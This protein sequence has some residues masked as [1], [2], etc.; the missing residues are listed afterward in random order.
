MI[1]ID[2]LLSLA[3]MSWESKSQAR[4]D[5]TRIQTG[6]MLKSKLQVSKK[7]EMLQPGRG[8]AP[9]MLGPQRK[10]GDGR[11][12]SNPTL[13]LHGHSQSIWVYIL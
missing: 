8:A 3:L 13:P 6:P 4:V 9:S 2:G 10:V 7:V 5:R 11:S 1:S 12:S